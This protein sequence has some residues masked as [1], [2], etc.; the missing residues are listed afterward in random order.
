MPQ[1]ILDAND[2]RTLAVDLAKAG[3]ALDKQTSGQI[4]REAAQPMLTATR[5][6]VPVGRIPFF[7][8]AAINRGRLKGSPGDYT[9]TYARGGATRRDLRLKV[10]DGIGDETARVLIGVD[11]R[12]GYVGWRT[13][14]ITRATAKD[15]S[16][17]DFLSR[18]EG[19][20]IDVVISRIG[21]AAQIVVRKILAK[22][23]A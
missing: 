12:S 9:G 11:K 15:P 10:V 1:P 6:E 17:N 3:R 18:A 23:S 21:P 16:V 4:M 2:I 20:T 13:H 14:F 7:K 8:S 22:Y 19:R 5:Q